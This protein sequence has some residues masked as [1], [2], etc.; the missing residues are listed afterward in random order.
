[1]LNYLKNIKLRLQFTGWLQYILPVVVAIFFLGIAGLFG[2]LNFLNLSYVFLTISV[3][4]F[5]ITLF[6]ITTI[7]FNIRPT[8]SLPRRRDDMDAFDLMRTRR[9][10]R[11]FQN[12]KLK[13]SDYSELLNVVREV[14]HQNN[15]KIG[16]NPIRFEYINAPLTVWPVVGAQ[17]FFVAI[18]PKNYSRQS[19]VDVGRNLQKVVHHATKMGLGTCWIGPGADQSSIAQ[20]LG[21]QFN[22][23]KDHIVCVCAIGYKSWFTPFFLRIMASVVQHRRLPISSLF[24]TDYQ[25]KKPLDEKVAPFD[26]FGRCYEVCQWAPSSFNSQTT[27]CVAVKEITNEEHRNGNTIPAKKSEIKL[28]RFDFYT[29]TKSRFYSPVA[30]GIWFANWEIGCEALGIK[31]HFEILSENDRSVSTMG[32]V[33]ELPIYDVSWVLD[34]AN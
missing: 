3:L 33:S 24:F 11:S 34:E 8:E 16:H 20:H 13:P 14:N 5:T 10:C 21:D 27:R 32:K 4:L 17:E 15:N 1:M 23:E 2:V 22:S 30:L 12:R 31:G 6:D 25:F 28:K 26:R 19:I 29:S 18:A 9:S 7:K